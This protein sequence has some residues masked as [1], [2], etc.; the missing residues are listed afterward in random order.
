[1]IIGNFAI[2]IFFIIII[3]LF[4]L[5]FCIPLIIIK[6]KGIDP[7]GTHEGYSFLTKLS[8]IAII[9]WL[10]YIILYIIFDRII[11][12]FWIMYFLSSDFFIVVGMVFVVISIILN[13]IATYSLGLNFRIELPKEDTELKTTGIYGFMRN[14]IVFALFL[15][16]IGSF[17][18]IPNII[19]LIITVFN[20]IAFD[21]KARDEEKFLLKR[22][23]EDY[24][25]Y[26][27]RVGRY[28]PFRIRIK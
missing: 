17:L 22:F 20:I 4:L 3:S 1:M 7:H 16:F 9:I 19:L 15:L 6:K 2:K 28:L 13:G 25:G 27:L 23:G 18:I 10:A 26:K 24:E 11:R 12:D 5:G 21:S 14:P 8:L